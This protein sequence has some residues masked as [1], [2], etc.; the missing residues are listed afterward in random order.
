MPP[1]PPDN[2][3]IAALLVA[4]QRLAA[5]LRDEN[6]A[7]A[8]L[9]LSLAAG[10]AEGKIRATDA[11]AAAHA[12]ATRHAARAGDVLAPRIAALAADL[13]QLGEENRR[14]LQRAVS[15][16][17]R[18]IETIAAAALPRASGEGTRYGAAGQR[19]A[20]YRPA[21]IAVQTRA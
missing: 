2:P 1:A 15:I 4:G 21:A 9:D 5:A 18:V 11:F 16:Q 20:T 12:A 13:S 3:L 14:L 6:A 8:A 7:L 10:L 17:S 19:A